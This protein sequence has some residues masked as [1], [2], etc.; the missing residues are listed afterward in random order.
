MTTRT[1]ACACGRLR[2]TVEGEPVVVT[3]CHCD[4]CQKMSGSA[5]QTGAQFAPEHVVEI[6][7]EE[8]VYNGLVIDGVGVAGS[9]DIA[10][11]YHFCPTCGAN[12]YRTMDGPF[13]MFAV[14][15][16][17]FVDPGFAAP[18]VETH[19][20]TRHHWVQ[21]VPGAAQFETFPTADDQE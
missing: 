1:A 15:V 13:P 14:A 6:S 17:N 20:V 5:F 7:G 4:F 11:D 16:G 19:T 21:P 18:V 8:R 12:V 9:D 2:V 10:I 3:L